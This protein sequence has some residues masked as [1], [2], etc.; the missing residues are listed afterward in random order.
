MQGS[1]DS[2]EHSSSSLPHRLILRADFLKHDLVRSFEQGHHPCVVQTQAFF[3][4]IRQP[5][6]AAISEHVYHDEHS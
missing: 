5:K 1:I 4:S 2:G 6:C 3:L